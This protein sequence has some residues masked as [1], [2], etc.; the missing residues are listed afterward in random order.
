MRRLA[1]IERK[2]L[3][4]LLIHLGEFDRRRLYAAWAQPSSFAYCVN[5]LGYSEQGAYKRIRAARAARDFPELLARLADGTANLAVVVILAPHLRPEN[6]HEL[7]DAARGRSARELETLVAGLAPRPDAPECM[8]AL[9]GPSAPPPEG[10]L[11]PFDVA[12]AAA[13]QEG[14]S[15]APAPKSDSA[16]PVEGPRESGGESGAPRHGPCERLEALSTRRFLF[17]FTGGASLRSKYDRALRV[18]G[19]FPSSTAM[20]RTFEAALDALL[21]KRDP[22]RRH[23]SRQERGQERA[24]S[25]RS[26]H[27]RRPAAALRDEVWTRDQGRCTFVGPD[28]S[29]CPEVFGLEIDHQLPFALGGSSED[30]ANLRLL[31]R[32]HNQ[33]MARRIFGEP[34]NAS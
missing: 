28:G 7:L 4:L 9:P 26:N 1:R 27:A 32:T 15:G 17:R 5:V 11:L 13:T 31:C 23:A 2:A 8:R 18:C 24:R 19:R 12:A 6:V 34:P 3:G 30:A 33:L 21:E 16:T 29:R 22:E 25:G 20:E 10:S 14:G